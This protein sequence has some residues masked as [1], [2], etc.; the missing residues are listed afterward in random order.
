MSLRNCIIIVLLD[1][2]ESSYLTN[3]QL[4]FRTHYFQIER[5]HDKTDLQKYL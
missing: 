1:K 4:I 3:V 5:R 2:N